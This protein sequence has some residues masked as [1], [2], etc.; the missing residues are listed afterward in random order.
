MR[1]TA[2]QRPPVDARAAIARGGAASAP[3]AATSHAHAIRHGSRTARSP[4]G[5]RTG[6][7]CP[8]RVEPAQVADQD[9]AAPD[10]AVGAVAGTV[11]DRADGGPGLAVLGQAGGEVRVVVLDGDELDALALERVGAS[12]R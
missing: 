4:P 7:R 11:E 1:A 3:S 2:S 9:L 12:S 5:R 6:R 10:R 8:T